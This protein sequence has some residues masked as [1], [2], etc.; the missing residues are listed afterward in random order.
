M[1]KLCPF[2]FSSL[3]TSGIPSYC[4]K[5]II[6]KKCK[7]LKELCAWYNEEA[8]SCCVCITSMLVSQQTIRMKEMTEKEISELKSR[9]SLL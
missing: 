5:E 7:C 1:E 9:L 6:E 3:N 8:S 2:L 4:A